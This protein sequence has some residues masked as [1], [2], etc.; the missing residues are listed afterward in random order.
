MELI[1]VSDIV[2]DSA[3]KVFS[4]PVNKGGRVK[5]INAKWSIDL[6][7][8]EIDYLSDLVSVYGAKGLAWIRVKPDGWQSPIT[9]FFT[10]A[11]KEAMTTRLQMDPGDHVFFVADTPEVVN[12][13][14]GHLRL[15]LGK[16]QYT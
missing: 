13:S 12:E 8:K 3:F 16:L 6:S 5:A 4:D 9:K 10:A 7:R 15:H 11:E 14:L 2:A 1:D